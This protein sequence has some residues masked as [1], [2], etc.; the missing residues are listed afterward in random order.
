M[1]CQSSGGKIRSVIG[2]VA[3][4][5]E[6]KSDKVRQGCQS[7]ERKI[8]SGILVGRV[9]SLGGKIRSRC[10]Q[11]CQSFGGKIRSG[12]GKVASLVTKKKGQGVG[13]VASLLV[14]KLGQV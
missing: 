5:L 12:V 14:E 2:R 4:L 10:R 8:R 11:G 9:A 13:R 6:E 3:S 1:S 7:S